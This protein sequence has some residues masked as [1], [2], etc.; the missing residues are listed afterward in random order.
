MSDEQAATPP[1]KKKSRWLWIMLLLVLML[2]GGGAG[3]WYMLYMQPAQAQGQD[4]AAEPTPAPALYSELRP[5][6][7]V[8]LAGNR[9][10]QLEIDLM[11]RD[12]A[13]IEAVK[14]HNPAIRNDL[15]L[16]LGSQK[17]SDLQS[18][19]GKVTL[20]QQVLEAINAILDAREQGLA[21]EEIYFSSFVMQ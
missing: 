1:K 15:L 5:A 10:L 17:P 2:G 8:N 16:L 18:L 9:F 6:F 19:E 4:E 14:R 20:Q 21:V 3:A 7:V 11:A 13:V 12:A